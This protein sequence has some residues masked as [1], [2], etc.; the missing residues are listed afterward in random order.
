MLIQEVGL[1]QRGWEGRPPLPSLPLSS[2]PGKPWL[3][4]TSAS[5]EP[6]YAILQGMKQKQLGGTIL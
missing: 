5:T 3:G 4:H 2:L 6:F 1:S